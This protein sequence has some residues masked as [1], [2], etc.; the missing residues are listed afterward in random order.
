MREPMTTV[1]I[2]VVED[3]P[4]TTQMVRFYLDR[5]H[6]MVSIAD[7][8]PAGLMAFQQHQPHLIILDVMLPRMDG[9]E[10]C[11]RIR[12]H[13]AVPILLLTARIEDTDKA[14]G[15]GIGADDYLTKP[16]S[17][18][19]LI[20]RVKALLR[21]AY[22]YNDPQPMRVILGGPRLRL[23]PARREL[24]LDGQI[25]DL[26]PTEFDLLQILMSNPG[27]A[28]TRAHLLEK[29]CGYTD[30]AGE[31]TVTAHMSN[32]RRKLGRLGAQVLRTVRGV[33]YAYEE[34]G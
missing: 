24:V 31:E 32:L 30:E 17:P 28:F 4:Q 10:V 19:E 20:A 11:R 6:F 25:V 23:D 8:G 26:T 27:W 16:F 18:I 7:D 34:E 9:L 22:Q 33:G 3:D 12:Q 29:V 2:L 21:R 1:R 13:S 15:L 5:E 14:I